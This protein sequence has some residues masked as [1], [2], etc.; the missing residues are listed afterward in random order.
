MIP[1]GLPRGGSLSC[2]SKNNKT[3][4]LCASKK[5][6][7]TEGYLQYRYG[8]PVSKTKIEFEFPAKR[9]ASHQ[10]FTYGHYFRAQVDRNNINFSNDGHEYVV[11]S[12]YDGEQKTPVKKSGV[13]VD[14]KSEILCKPSG[15][16]ENWAHVEGIVPCE[17]EDA[18]DCPVTK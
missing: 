13:R 8:N 6:T 15:A 18:I 5:L 7:A 11:F 14:E 10:Q 16:I 4:S 17:D 12:E 9:A 1:R 3:I 2:L